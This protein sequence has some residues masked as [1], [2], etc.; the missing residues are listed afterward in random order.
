MLLLLEMHIYAVR[1]H[2]MA[3]S[4]RRLAQRKYNRGFPTPS[5]QPAGQRFSSTAEA[6]RAQRSRI[7]A[8]SGAIFAALVWATDISQE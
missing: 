3:A 6:Q 5:R 4:L 2:E 1:G 7:L 8:L